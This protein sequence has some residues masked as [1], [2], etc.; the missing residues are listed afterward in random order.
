MDEVSELKSEPIIYAARYHA[1][2]LWPLGIPNV[3]DGLSGYTRKLAELVAP[4]GLVPCPKILCNVGSSHGTLYK[5]RNTNFRPLF[6]TYTNPV[7]SRKFAACCPGWYSKFRVANAG[8]NTGAARMADQ[9]CV[10]R[11][12]AISFSS[13]MVA[14]EKLFCGFTW[15]I[16]LHLR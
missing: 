1:V 10:C 13:F 8:M 7:P 14:T 12:C 4:D 9:N 6:T 3:C 2:W 5:C 16:Q 15:C 11:T